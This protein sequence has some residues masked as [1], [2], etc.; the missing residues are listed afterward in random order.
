M[1][2][3]L[4]EFGVFR[5]VAVVPTYVAIARDRAGLLSRHLQLL[6]AGGVE[7]GKFRDRGHLAEQPQSVE[8]A[9][10]KRSGRPRQ[11]CG[12]PDLAFDSLDELADHLRRSLDL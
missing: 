11:L 12:P 8:P 4:G 3:R 9:L 10:I 7:L 1:R 6:L 5:I 2:H